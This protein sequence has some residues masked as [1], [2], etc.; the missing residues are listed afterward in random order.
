MRIVSV[1]HLLSLVRCILIAYIEPCDNEQLS[2]FVVFTVG[3]SNMVRAGQPYNASDG[4]LEDHMLVAPST[5]PS[6]R[7]LVNRDG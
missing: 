5:T 6:S 4:T 1:T 7:E 3:H 2:R